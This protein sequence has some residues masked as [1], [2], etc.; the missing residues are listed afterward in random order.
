MTT[1]KKMNDE[2][3]KDV[4]GECSKYGDVMNVVVFVVSDLSVIFNPNLV[5]C[6]F[7]LNFHRLPKIPKKSRNEQVRIFIEYTDLESAYLA[8]KA[9][10]NITYDDREL[11]V[12]FYDAEHYYAYKFD[13][14]I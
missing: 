3:E 14:E 11:K 1:M 4:K 10:N 7:L 6:K 12:N 5:F 13:E 2:L 8:R 9:L